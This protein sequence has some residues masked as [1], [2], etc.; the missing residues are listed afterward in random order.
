MSIFVL[1]LFISTESSHNKE[2]SYTSLSNPI[3]RSTCQAPIVVSATGTLQY[4]SLDQA[5]NMIVVFH[6]IQGHLCGL[7]VRI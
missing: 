1:F 7:E 6:H 2:V 3:K 4:S 5:I